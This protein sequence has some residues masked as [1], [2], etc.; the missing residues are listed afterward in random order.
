MAVKLAYKTSMKMKQLQSSVEHQLASEKEKLKEHFMKRKRVLERYIKG[1]PFVRFLDK[2]SFVIGVYLLVA[3][4]YLVGRHPHDLYYQYHCA[5]V[6]FLVALRFYNYKSK[7]W[8]YYLFDFCYY[9][10]AIIIVFLLYAPKNEILFKLLFV[11]SNGFFGFA[12]PAFKNSMIFH[13]IDNLISL[14]I[15]VIPQVTSWNLKWH[16][17][18]YELTLKEEDRYFLTLNSKDGGS[19]LNDV[20]GLFVVP[21]VGYLVWMVFYTLKIFVISSKRIKDRNYETMYV[22]YMNQ[23]KIANIFKVFGLDYAPLVFM[24]LHVFFF[25]LTALL[26]IMAY[27]SFYIHTFLLLTWITISIWNGA[28]F[29]MEYFSRKYEVNLKRLE[30]IE[31]QLTDNQ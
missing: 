1:S 26:A 8:H 5:V 6:S 14:A 11:Y 25:I 13:R 29:Y 23:P 12:V 16:T 30:E 22:Y 2:I 3:T 21:F 9:A 28:N 18:P 17:M 31:M 15:H 20:M 24:C 7:G 4:T 27:T 19:F 10:N